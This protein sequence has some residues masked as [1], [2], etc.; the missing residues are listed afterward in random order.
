MPWYIAETIQYLEN[1]IRRVIA[2]INYNLL[3]WVSENSKISLK[4]K[5]LVNIGFQ[6]C[7][8]LTEAHERLFTGNHIWMINGTIKSL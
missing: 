2:D 1:N 7:G 6:D 4:K 8:T 3:R 5:K